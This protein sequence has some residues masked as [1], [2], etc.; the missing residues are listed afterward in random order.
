MYDTN[1][2]KIKIY[3]V[4]NDYELI[5]TSTDDYLND[6]IKVEYG[7]F[8]YSTFP[9]ASIIDF[10]WE[11]VNEFTPQG[12]VYD[13][14]M[15][16]SNAL[17]LNRTLDQGERLN[18]TFLASK[19]YYIGT[20]FVENQSSPYASPS[21]PSVNNDLIEFNTDERLTVF[22]GWNINTSNTKYNSGNGKI[23]FPTNQNVNV[24]ITNTYEGIVQIFDSQTDEVICTRAANSTG[25]I[26]IY[27]LGNG[28]N[29]GV[30]TYAQLPTFTYQLI[31]SATLVSELWN[32]TNPDTPQ[33]L[34]SVDGLVAPNVMSTRKELYPGQKMFFKLYGGNRPQWIGF[35]FIAQDPGVNQPILSTLW[36]N[37]LRWDNTE[38][39]E[40][41][42]AFKW[43]LNTSNSAYNST[44]QEWESPNV[45]TP[46][47][48]YW[49]YEKNTNSLQLWSVTQVPNEL[50]ATCDDTQNGQGI[51]FSI[52][53]QNPFPSI[54]IEQIDTLQV[55]DLNA[56]DPTLLPKISDQS[57]SIRQNRDL[58]YQLVVDSDSAFIS[59]YAFSN[60]PSGVLGDTATG[61]ITGQMP[62]QGSYNINV[63]VFNRYG[64]D[65][66]VLTLNA[67]AFSQPSTD[68]NSAYQIEIAN[69]TVQRFRKIDNAQANNPIMRNTNGDG[70]AFTV[71][72]AIEQ[73]DKISPRAGYMLSVAKGSDRRFND[74][75]RMYAFSTGSFLWTYGA[76][77]TGEIASNYFNAYDINDPY[78]FIVSFDGGTTGGDANDKALYLSRF[79]AYS[80]NLRTQVVTQLSANQEIL[81]VDGFTGN[82]DGS[83]FVIGQ[84]F[85]PAFDPLPVDYL[86]CAV[87]QHVVPTT[88]IL[89]FATNPN[90]YYSDNG[91]TD[92]LQ[93]IGW[94]FG[95]NISDTQTQIVNEVDVNNSIQ[96]LSIQGM[97]NNNKKIKNI[98]NLT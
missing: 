76:V 24:Y 84:D 78:A 42:S 35:G 8:R 49:L 47:E 66:C 17:K 50:V 75:F 20:G 7:S 86:Y 40:Q 62:A 30:L 72:V 22:K 23:E 32:I 51:T 6:S 61:I 94:S 37:Y 58:N 4:T 43:T 82:L 85:T 67:L 95:D 9:T 59:S 10:D 26:P 56:T 73:Y 27:L 70:K 3:N 68:W 89:Q 11:I 13:D 83:S 98:D 90:K 57:L 41:N 16:I 91:Y 5:A 38:A 1:L 52:G 71:M 69:Q 15:K 87:T 79:T 54:P 64:S 19:L 97:N 60:L 28:A 65:T 93:N 63:E 14:G 88:D 12:T 21:N 39:I 2:N 25:P 45:T 18:L 31:S 55:E 34:V 46:S 81:Y 36:D 74:G 80:V 92:P 53:L 48:F 29:N 77:N 33:G 44:T 96:K